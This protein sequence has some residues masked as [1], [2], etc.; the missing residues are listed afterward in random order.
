M[1]ALAPLFAALAALSPIKT[2]LRRAAQVDDPLALA[3]LLQ[4][5]TADAIDAD[6][7][8][9]GRNALHHAAWRGPVENVELLLDMGCDIN[10]WSTGLHCFGKTPIFYATTR[11][12]DAVVELLLQRGARIRILNNKGQ[13]VLSLAATHL[14]ASTCQRVEAAERAETTRY[15]KADD[16]WLM[17]IGRQPTDGPIA[18]GP[19]M[20]ADGW[21]DFQSSHPSCVRTDTPPRVG[22][23]VQPG[24]LDPRFY[25]E[26]QRSSTDVITR[27]V[28][29]PSTRESRRM[30]SHLSREQS[31][32]WWPGNTRSSSSEDKAEQ[33]PTARAA[34]QGH[35][36]FGLSDEEL[37][38][39]YEED[40][41]AFQ[42]ALD[43]HAWLCRT[44]DHVD[45]KDEVP[46]GFWR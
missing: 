9:S 11:C 7:D 1:A 10:R 12:R 33:E 46:P 35:T 2:S 5:L 41:A 6:T 31:L 38:A 32:N 36:A 43:E 17:K 22:L 42:Q 14:D 44:S 24:D 15:S 45:V 27:L 23:D 4:G 25:P 8:R 29:N 18:L 20:C 13:S 16:P 3:S 21:V 34:P 39:A 26:A 28:V 19:A 37:E 30:H 40:F